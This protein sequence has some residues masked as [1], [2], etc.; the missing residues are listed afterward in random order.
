MKNIKSTLLRE[1]KLLDRERQIRAELS[2]LHAE[3]NEGKSKWTWMQTYPGG[4]VLNIKLAD[5]LSFAPDA[6]PTL[7]EF[8]YDERRLRYMKY[9]PVF[10][11]DIRKGYHLW[12]S[13][14]TAREDS[15]PAIKPEPDIQPAIDA[16]ASKVTH[17]TKDA[18]ALDAIAR[19]ETA[20][21]TQD[22][23]QANGCL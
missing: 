9:P 5:Y 4:M 16:I 8:N 11:G 7:V 15:G 14:E 21:A 22:R 19:V 13:A 12:V 23:A 20:L 2:K 3:R 6:K 10:L 17:G 18:E 1:A